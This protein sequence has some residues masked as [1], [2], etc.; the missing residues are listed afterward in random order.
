MLISS[1]YLRYSAVFREKQ[2]MIIPSELA[3]LEFVAYKQDA[4]RGTTS[5]K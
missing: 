4:G 2:Y 5:E 3:E 1:S